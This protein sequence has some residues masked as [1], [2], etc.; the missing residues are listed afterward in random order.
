[1]ELQLQVVVVVFV[2]GDVL[3][4]MLCNQSKCVSKKG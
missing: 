3:D 4:V 1:M 2:V